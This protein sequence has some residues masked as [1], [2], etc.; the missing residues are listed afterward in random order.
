[1]VS[2]TTAE[3]RRQFR[4]L[5]KEVQ[6]QARAAFAVFK[7]DPHHPGLRFKKLAPHDDL[8]SARINR[9]YRAIGRWRGEVILW[10]FIGAHRDYEAVIKRR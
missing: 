2:R 8:W 9:D 7:L 4:Q 6:R 10:Y 5:P 3:F 1:M